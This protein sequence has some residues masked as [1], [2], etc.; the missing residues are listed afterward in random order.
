MRALSI[1]AS[2]LLASAATAA[3]DMT[4]TQATPDG[5]DRATVASCLRDGGQ[6]P[7]SCIGSIAVPC[8]ARQG[9]AERSVSQI[10]C[11]RREAG[12]WRERLDMAGNL[13][14]AQLE[15]GAR[16]RFS[17]VQRAWESYVAQKC[18]LLAEIST[19]VQAAATQ[20]ACELRE[21]ALR[22]IDVEQ[23]A[24]RARESSAAPRRPEVQR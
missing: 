11:S 24:R 17:A 22:A 13:A 8:S 1:F 15:A 5:T 16:S 3:A 18:G 19:P 10:T 12:V 4:P 9:S 6:S 14:A 7:Q 2:M 20:A 21:V 23:I